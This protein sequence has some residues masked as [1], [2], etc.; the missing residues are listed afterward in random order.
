MKT[1]TAPSKVALEYSYSGQNHEPYKEKEGAAG[2]KERMLSYGRPHKDC[3][4]FKQI[5]V[6]RSQIMT[7]RVIISTFL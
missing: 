3:S 5:S 4:R 7:M 6:V 1:S 2:V